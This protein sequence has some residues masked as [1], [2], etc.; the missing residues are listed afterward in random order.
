MILNYFDTKIL[1]DTKRNGA[2]EELISEKYCP[3]IQMEEG[4]KA[5]KSVEFSVE[6]RICEDRLFELD[7]LFRRR[8]IHGGVKKDYYLT[9]L[10]KMEDCFRKV[11]V[12]SCQVCVLSDMQ[13]KEVVLQGRDLSSV[14][15]IFDLVI[16]ELFYRSREI[17]NG[18]FH[19][20]ASAIAD[21]NQNGTIFIGDKNAGK[22]TFLFESVL[23]RGFH[24]VCNDNC[25]V[26]Y[27]KNRSIALVPWFEDIKVKLK[28]LEQYHRNM[29]C[30]TGCEIS[31]DGEKVFLPLANGIRN[32]QLHYAGTVQLKRIVILNYA[33]GESRIEI[34]WQSARAEE[35]YHNVKIPHDLEHYE[36]LGLF[37]EFD[38]DRFD[39]L[40][41]MIGHLGEEIEVLKVSYDIH[42]MESIF[43]QLFEKIQE[44][45]GRISSREEKRDMIE[46][47]L[48]VILSEEQYE[49]IKAIF[50]WDTD[51]C[52][53][54]YYYRD[55]EDLSE[56][57]GITIRIREKQG[58]YLLQVKVPVSEQGSL[59]IKKEFEKEVKGIAD[60]ISGSDLTE[61]TE[62]TFSDAHFVGELVTQRRTCNAYEGIEICL[63][64]SCYFGQTDYELEI[65]YTQEYPR[66]VVQILTEAGIHFEHAVVGK[67]SRFLNAYIAQ[68]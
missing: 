2:L 7:T 39:R 63:D 4:G 5:D 1:V 9:G 60:T 66:E 61:L 38:N 33:P 45:N 40:Q 6:L 8:I 41:E 3:V 32:L 22:T 59:H 19:F 53:T 14:F 21:E 12:D 10:E 52:Q 49:T 68:R 24:Y 11:Y 30:T 28:T 25:F 37:D 44:R 64:R 13:K 43:D 57:N 27:G 26:E 47:E 20:H 17:K 48:K 16:I 51:V 31:P 35:I 34:G 67:Y 58:R 29:E 56:N 54:N 18:S 23:Q 42:T 62:L 65:E 55:T 46:K 15:K 36:F 50:H